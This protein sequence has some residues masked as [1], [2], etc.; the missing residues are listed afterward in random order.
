MD[1]TPRLPP[2][3]QLRRWILRQT[4]SLVLLGLAVHLILPQLPAIEHSL[5]VTRTMTWWIVALAVLAEICSYLGSGY[6]L[7]SLAAVSGQHLSIVRGAIITVASYSVG[8][9]A[10][11]TVGSAAVTYRWMRGS[12]VRGEAAII[13]GWLPTLLYDIVLAALSI[14]GLV[15]LFFLHLLDSK[16]AILIGAIFVMLGA[17]LLSVLWGMRHRGRLTH[18][19]VQVSGR[20]AAWRSRP[21]DPAAIWTRAQRF[22]DIYDS[23][24]AGGWRHPMLGSTITVLF[25]MLTLYLVFF[26]AG[27]PI[28][29]GVLMTGYGIPMLLGKLPLLPGGIGIV[30]ATMTALFVGLGVPDGIAVVCTLV[31]RLISFWLPLLIGFPWMAYLQHTTRR[32]IMPGENEIVEF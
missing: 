21:H 12:G 6:I 30:E 32:D 17:F 15:Y 25:D 11:G 14:F 27:Y 28:G 19:A 20:W 18:F 5:Q 7:H 13:G 8:L 31:Y 22:F 26:A 1:Q 9:V 2:S 23:L 24:I 10:G 4:I 29:F 3:P 16:Q